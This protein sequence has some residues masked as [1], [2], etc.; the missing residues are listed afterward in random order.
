MRLDDRYGSLAD[1]LPRLPMSAFRS[2]ADIPG[3]ESDVRFVPIAD[4]N[5]NG[6]LAANE[7]SH[8]RLGLGTGVTGRICLATIVMQIT[9]MISIAMT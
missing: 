2:K 5:E 7:S 4:L 6:T 1:I 8:A 3:R 9:L